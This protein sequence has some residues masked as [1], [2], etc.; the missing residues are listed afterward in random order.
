M[1]YIIGS[2]W[3]CAQSPSDAASDSSSDSSCDSPEE[4]R[5]TF[6]DDQIRSA[7]FHALWYDSICHTSKPDKIVIVDSC[8]PVK[9]ALNSKDE[10]IEFISLNEN[11][12]HSTNHNGKYC[13]W[14]RS[15][16]LS[17]SYAINCDCDYYVYVEQDVLLSGK[18]LIEHEIEQ[19]RG[20]Y[21]FGREPSLVQPLQ[22]SMFIIKH[23]A[24]ETFLSRFYAISATDNQVSPERKFAIASSWFLSLLPSMLFRQPP[25][26]NVLGKVLHRA[27]TAVLKLF[28]GFGTLQMGYGRQRPI[29]FSAP[30]Y[31]FQHG[32]QEEL[33]TFLTRQQSDNHE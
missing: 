4:V 6:G 18:G 16:L 2:G 11:A 26:T 21:A 27:Q 17:L 10:R 25:L 33:A 9:P 8:S 1:K 22:Q 32:S 30:H 13:G 19:M 29:D 3:W 20:K 12:G 24:I 15:V 14:T 31:Y 7:G 5:V 23:S 28:G